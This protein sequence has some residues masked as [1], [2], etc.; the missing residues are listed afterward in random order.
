M[1]PAFEHFDRI[2]E[3]S[4]EKPVFMVSNAVVKNS[5]GSGADDIPALAVIRT[6][7]ACDTGLYARYDD[8]TTGVTTKCL[9]KAED[10]DKLVFWKD[11][12]ILDLVMM[13]FLVSAAK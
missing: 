2:N 3:L 9:I 5:Y 12:T 10:Y 4:R 1:T 8:L 11:L 13:N 7:F 6:D